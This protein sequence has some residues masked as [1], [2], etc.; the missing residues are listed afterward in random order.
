MG[1]ARRD[2]EASEPA[3]S[4]EESAPRDVLLAVAP[5]TDGEGASVLRLRDGRVET[6]ELRAAREGQPIL[7]ELVTLKPRAEHA[8]LYDVEVVASGPVADRARAAREA[9]DDE[10]ERARPAPALPH[11][12]PALVNSDAYREGWEALF[13]APRRGKALPS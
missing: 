12:G 3:P 1:D 10:P 13:G 6:G 4:I 5:T 2:G 9:T 7:G 11:K 8:S